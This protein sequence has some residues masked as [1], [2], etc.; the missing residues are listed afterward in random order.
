MDLLQTILNAQGGEATRQAGLAVGLA[1]DE[2]QSALAALIPALAGGL[3]RNASQ[4]SGLDA[5]VSALTSGG[6]T[7]YLDNPA[8]LGQQGTVSD[9]NRIL[10]HI[11]GSKDTSRAVAA[12]ASARTGIG[13]EV[14]KK[15]LPIA[16]TMVMSSLAKQRTSQS[17][18]A[19]SAGSG[20]LLDMLSPMLDRD[21]DGSIVDD[22][23]GGRRS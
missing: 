11:L 3:H 16:A 4:P 8:A 2:T 1:P 14:L 13:A 18:P 20:G 5:L 22:L 21:G 12:Q 19:A 15:L 23:L 10:G 6:H 7:Q 17:H 9:G